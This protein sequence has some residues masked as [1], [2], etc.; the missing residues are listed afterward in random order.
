MRI[1]VIGL[2]L[3]LATLPLGAQTNDVGVWYSTAKIKDSTGLSFDNAKGF[4]VSFNHFWTGASAG[5]G[6]LSTEFSVSSLRAN[7]GIDIAG[8]RALDAGRLKLMPFTANWQWHIARGSMFAPYIGGGLA[9]V[10]AKDL[11]SADLDAAGIGRVKIDHKATWDANAGVNIG[12]GK[13]FAVAIDARSAMTPMH[14]R[15]IHF[16]AGKPELGS[17]VVNF[18][19]PVYSALSLID[20]RGPSGRFF[21][22]SCD[23]PEPS[24][25]DALPCQRTEFVFGNVEPTGVLRGMVELDPAH[26][27]SSSFRI[28]RLVKRPLGVRI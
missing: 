13:M 27:L 3:A 28:K 17:D 16:K 12:I 14:G 9:Y 8:T 21:C 26:Q 11:S 1:H 22:Q 23:V 20:V 4:G 10:S 2:A 25:R 24:A 19:L 15:R 7:G 5:A 18:H 6:A